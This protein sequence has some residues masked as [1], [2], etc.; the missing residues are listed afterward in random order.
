MPGKVS[1]DIPRVEILDSGT[2]RHISPY[3]A[4][5]NSLVETKPKILRAANKNRFSALGVGQ[6]EISVPNG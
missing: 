5:F 6:L 3:K 1:N 4:D 2:T